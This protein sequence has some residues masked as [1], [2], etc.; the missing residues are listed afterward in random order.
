MKAIEIKGIKGIEG[1]KDECK[2]K[3]TVEIKSLSKR[4]KKSRTMTIK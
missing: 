4:E 2:G 1:N 3:E